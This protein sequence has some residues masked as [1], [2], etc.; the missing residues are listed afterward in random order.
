MSLNIVK[1][2]A[3][4]TDELQLPDAIG[5]G[6]TSGRGGQWGWVE[7]P[8]R[9]TDELGTTDLIQ[10]TATGA[11]DLRHLIPAGTEFHFLIQWGLHSGDAY[12]AD[13]LRSDM[14]D[15]Q[16]NYVELG[17]RRIEDNR[18]PQRQVLL[19]VDLSSD[20]SGRGVVGGIHKLTGTGTP[21]ADATEELADRID[22]IRSWHDR[23]AASSFDATPAFAEQIAWSIS[24]SLHR[25][26]SWLPTGDLISAGQMLRLRSADVRPGGMTHIEVHTPTG[27]KY[28][29][30]LIPSE[31]GFPATE[32]E[33]P[34]GEWLK[35]LS[36]ADLVHEDRGSTGP[37]EVSIRGRNIPQQEAVKR[38]RDALA[39]VKDQR[40][41]AAKGIAGDPASEVNEA[42][43]ILQARLDEVLKGQVGM[44]EDQVTWIVEGDS[45]KEVNAR[46]QR[47][48]DHYAGK[49]ITIWCP[50]AIQDLLW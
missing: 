38:L 32:M 33:L 11:N 3:R 46:A 12:R 49:G 41:S 34:G 29:K 10:L 28:L 26:V 15:G 13:E 22:R 23:M 20:S 50:P 1:Q 48:I 6:V 2:F 16:A 19:G 8:G 37:V 43:E 18:F 47:V 5:T 42:G 21:A 36:I 31:K 40:R 44:I 27:I 7:L 45:I 14:T 24:R 35:E 25:C 17:P 9:S 4:D 39:M 30:L